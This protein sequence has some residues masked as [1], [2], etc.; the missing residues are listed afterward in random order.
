VIGAGD[1][2]HVVPGTWQLEFAPRTLV[3]AGTADALPPVS[4]AVEW[5]DR[6]EHIMTLQE[7]GVQLRIGSMSNGAWRTLE[8]TVPSQPPMLVEFDR[9][10]LAQVLGAERVQLRLR[11]N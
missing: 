8:V 7:P 10:A 1:R 4:D 11:G 9:D 3:R 6:L 5:R 2:Q